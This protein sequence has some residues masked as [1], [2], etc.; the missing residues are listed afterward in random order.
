MKKQ[1][2]QTLTHSYRGHQPNPTDEA[3]PNRLGALVHENHFGTVRIDWAARQ[4]TLRPTT[5]ADVPG[6]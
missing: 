1:D 3:G 4:L 2:L 6:T 5:S